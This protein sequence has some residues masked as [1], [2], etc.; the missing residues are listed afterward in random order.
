MWIW[1]ARQS[2]IYVYHNSHT[3]MA[4]VLCLESRKSSGLLGNY[5]IVVESCALQHSTVCYISKVQID[6]PGTA[7]VPEWCFSFWESL[8]L[9]TIG[10]VDSR[11]ELCVCGKDK[12]WKFWLTSLLLRTWDGEFFSHQ[13]HWC[14]SAEGSKGRQLSLILLGVDVSKES[15]MLLG[16]YVNMLE[17]HLGEFW[18]SGYDF[19]KVYILRFRSQLWMTQGTEV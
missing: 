10:T 7:E 3:Y 2:C 14:V 4:F 11:S 6:I 19:P 12:R 13:V 1:G 9:L 8:S 16:V 17:K 5:H 15:D 18:E